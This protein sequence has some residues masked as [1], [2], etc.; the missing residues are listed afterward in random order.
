LLCRQLLLDYVEATPGRPEG[1]L[2]DVADHLLSSDAKLEALVHRGR[3][4]QLLCPI[5]FDMAA[6]L[7]RRVEVLS[8]DPGMPSN[9]AEG[10]PEGG[11]DCQAARDESVAL[12][13]ELSPHGRVV[14]IREALQDA[15]HEFL[16]FA[17]VGVELKR[18][19]GEHHPV[20]DDSVTPDVDSC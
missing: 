20:E 3:H 17:V 1:L 7:D 4:F 18:D 19:E 11:V 8:G 9:L 16:H 12:R 10:C 5:G 14:G 13:R 2:L 6:P 15:R